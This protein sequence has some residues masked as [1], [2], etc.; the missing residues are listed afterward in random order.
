MIEN[1]CFCETYCHCGI[2][3]LKTRMQLPV[4]TD[5]QLADHMLTLARITEQYAVQTLLPAIRE[6]YDSLGSVAEKM[7]FEPYGYRHI[8]HA[9]PRPGSPGLLTVRIETELS[10]GR[11]TLRHA[12]TAVTVDGRTG[13]IVKPKKRRTKQ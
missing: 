3:M 11:E 13:Q 10:H 1:T 6:A 5:G 7:H 8:W 2:P 4:M 12:E 9:E